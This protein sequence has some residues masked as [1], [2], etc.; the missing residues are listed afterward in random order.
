MA[1]AKKTGESNTPKEDKLDKLIDVLASK[2]LRASQIEEEK[3]K[4]AEESDRKLTE[5]ANSKRAKVKQRYATEPMTSIYLPPEGDKITNI[6]EIRDPEDKDF[7]K[8][9]KTVKYDS[10]GAPHVVTVCNYKYYIPKGTTCSVPMSIAKKIEKS[11]QIKRQGS[12]KVKEMQRK[13]AA[14]NKNL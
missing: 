1:Q 14:E 10:Y 4:K 13:K 7:L 9:K 11:R 2:E 3:Q 5:I 8:N 6:V 12:D